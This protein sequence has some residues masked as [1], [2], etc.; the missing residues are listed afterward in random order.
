MSPRASAPAWRGEAGSRASEGDSRQ[1]LLSPGY[2][3]GLLHYWRLT[4][5]E[6]RE[7]TGGRR[8]RAL[9]PGEP[10][11]EAESRRVISLLFL[12]K[13]RYILF[14]IHTGVADLPVAAEYALPGLNGAEISRKD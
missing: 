14:G 12:S 9:R 4:G 1:S 3:P 11:H 5:V 10:R 2:R 13:C 6:G 8:E 7:A